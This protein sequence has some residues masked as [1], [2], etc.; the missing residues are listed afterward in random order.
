M[1]YRNLFK[2]GNCPNTKE[3]KNSDTCAE[4]GMMICGKCGI[5]CSYHKVIDKITFIACDDLIFAT[6]DSYRKSAINAF[7]EESKL[8]IL[9]TLEFEAFFYVIVK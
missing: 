6:L 3:V 4:C 8:Q 1:E 7:C 9:E 5:Y 2:C